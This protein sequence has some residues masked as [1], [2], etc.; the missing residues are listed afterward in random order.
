MP[1]FTVGLSPAR[2]SAPTRARKIAGMT[3]RDTT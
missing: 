2:V 3:N 1:T